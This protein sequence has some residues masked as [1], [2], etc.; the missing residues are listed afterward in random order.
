MRSQTWRPPVLTALEK[1]AWIEALRLF[2]GW[3]VPDF[4]IRTGAG[5]FLP[6]RPSAAPSDGPV[7]MST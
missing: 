7:R 4:L 3:T 2:V 6:A 5:A 1:V